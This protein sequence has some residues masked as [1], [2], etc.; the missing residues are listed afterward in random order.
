MPI[1]VEQTEES[2]IGWSGLGNYKWNQNNGT[3]KLDAAA[4]FCRL[5]PE[6]WKLANI[7]VLLQLC[8]VRG[9]GGHVLLAR[10]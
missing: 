1:R 2:R 10:G 6:S 8:Y 4:P 9:G 3:P 5:E 7:R